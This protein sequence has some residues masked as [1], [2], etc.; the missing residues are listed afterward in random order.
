MTN[1]KFG[2]II[3]DLSLF[4]FGPEPPCGYI[5]AKH[6]RP[7]Y[8]KGER[9]VKAH[10]ESRERERDLENDRTQ[11]M[12]VLRWRSCHCRIRRLFDKLDVYNKRKRQ[13]WMQVPGIH[14]EQAIQL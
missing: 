8:G 2:I 14:G 3:M 12:P 5:K 9:L 13:E 10:S 11:K 1:K 4:D 7:A 6:I